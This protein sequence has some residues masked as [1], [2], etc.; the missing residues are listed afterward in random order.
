MEENIP[1]K[2]KD[3]LFHLDLLIT[4]KEAQCLVSLFWILETAYSSL[5]CVTLSHLPKDSENC[6]FGMRPGVEKALR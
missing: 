6:H 1:S 3:K 2:M 4:K 5:E